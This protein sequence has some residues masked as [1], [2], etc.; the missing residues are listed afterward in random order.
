[1]NLTSIC[2]Q[3]ADPGMEGMLISQAKIDDSPGQKLDEQDEYD[4]EEQVVGGSDL[5]KQQQ[6]KRAE[7]IGMC[8]D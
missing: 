3:E 4:A 5:E 1:M 7:N 8:G 6:Q 2:P